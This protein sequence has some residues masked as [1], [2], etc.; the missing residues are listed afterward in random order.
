MN[1]LGCLDT[2]TAGEYY[3]DGVDVANA[4]KRELAVIRN[5]KLGF[6][7]QGFNLLPRTTALEMWNFL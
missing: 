2:P 3:L 7:F 1:V 5:K 4:S 6:I